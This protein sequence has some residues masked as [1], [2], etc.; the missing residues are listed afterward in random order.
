MSTEMWPKVSPGPSW[1][2]T[3][4][5][6]TTSTTPARTTHRWSRGGPSAWTMVVPAAT[7]STSRRATRRR[8]SSAPR[9][10]YGAWLPRKSA[11]SFTGP[12]SRLP[13]PTAG[14]L[15]VSA[16][17]KRSGKVL[18]RSEDTGRDHGQVAQLV[19]ASD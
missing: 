16:V 6:S 9:A 11:Y 12:S 7:Y 4:P 2:T 14:T 3:L 15:P 1:S 10:S 8:S 18:S 13:A 5:R 17:A 19:R